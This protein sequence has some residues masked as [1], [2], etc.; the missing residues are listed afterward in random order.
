MAQQITVDDVVY[1][2]NPLNTVA[3]AK[4][5]VE[6][7]TLTPANGVNYVTFIPRAAPFFRRTM[8]LKNKANNQ[9]LVEGQHYTL[10]YFFSPFTQLVYK[11]VYGCIT[12]NELDAPIE[13]EITYDTIGGDFVLDAT[14]Y[15]ELAAN[16]VNNPRELDWSQ[17]ADTPDTYPPIDHTH[18]ADQTLNYMDYVEQL[19]AMQALTVSAIT[20]YVQALNTHIDTEGN[21][22]NAKPIDFGLGNVMNWAPAVSAD[23][24]SGG[25]TLYASLAIVKQTFQ[26]LFGGAT[27]P[28]LNSAIIDDYINAESVC[29]TLNVLNEASLLTTDEVTNLNLWKVYRAQM[30]IKASTGTTTVLTPP[31]TNA[32]FARL[33]GV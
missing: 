13:V 28:A 3:G 16:I 31:D 11:G 12:V 6:S 15:A 19:Q 20:G 14:G 24:P 23:I 1:P 25:A 26:Y 8:V 18:P 27:V 9:V 32:A 30:L 10:G 7:H 22:H 2:F 33:L 29:K 4:G 17:I 5:I 21:A